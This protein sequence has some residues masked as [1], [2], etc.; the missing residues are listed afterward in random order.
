MSMLLPLPNFVQSAKVSKLFKVSKI[1]KF[2][3][4]G[5]VSTKTRAALS[6]VPWLVNGLL[7][8]VA[9]LALGI[10]G[11]VL[12]GK[13]ATPAHALGEWLGIGRSVFAAVDKVLLAT[14]PTVVFFVAAVLV[15]RNRA[16]TAG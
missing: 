14:L 5:E 6:H 11:T 2:L 9:L 1:L 15:R 4:L 12:D 8:A 13:A 7:I 16:M 3:H 10:I